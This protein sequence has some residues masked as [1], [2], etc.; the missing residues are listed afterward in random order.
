LSQLLHLD[1]SADLTG[2]TS[3]ALTA[4]FADSWHGISPEH[5]VIY[6]DLHANPLPHL[7][8]N[9]AHWAPRL[10]VPGEE[11]APEVEELQ[12]QLIEEV[13]SADAVVIGAPMYNWGIPSTLKAWLDHI[14]VLGTTMPIDGPTQPFVG[15]PVVVVSSRGNTYASGTPGE[16]TDFVVPTLREVLGTALGMDVSI[17]LAE[18]T[19]ATRV[20]PLAS[21]APQGAASLA[22]ARATLVELAKSIGTR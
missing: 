18:L 5:S 1:S 7:P 8:T 14:C 3:R 19:L 17:V 20:A 9:A 13:I 16:G 12:Q 2:S 10:R 4:L 15:K 11:V 21:L 6:R 22:A